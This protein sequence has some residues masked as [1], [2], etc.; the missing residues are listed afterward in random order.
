MV[1]KDEVLLITHKRHVL[2]GKVSA[3]A[4]CKP[5]WAHPNLES[6]QRYYLRIARQVGPN[7]HDVVYR[8]MDQDHP[9]S[10]RRIR[11]LLSLRKSYSNAILDTAASQ[12]LGQRVYSY[13]YVKNVCLRLQK[14]VGKPHPAVL[15]QQHDLI[16][17]LTD[18]ENLVN[19]RT[20]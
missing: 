16:R 2:P 15:T 1:Y 5:R 8:I 17:D 20:S 9:L 13:H 7:L 19:E 14:N 10:I 6:Q 4:S 18:Y 3:P 11:G 12:A